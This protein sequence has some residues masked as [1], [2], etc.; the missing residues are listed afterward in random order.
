MHSGAGQKTRE[1]KS[2]PL[3][4]LH[5]CPFLCH[6]LERGR[7]S[8]KIREGSWCAP[9]S[10]AKLLVSEAHALLVIF[11]VSACP[12]SST[13]SPGIMTK[14]RSICLFGSCAVVCLFL[15]SS[16]F[17][18]HKMICLKK[19]SLNIVIPSEES[20]SSLYPRV[21]PH[22]ILW[23]TWVGIRQVGQLEPNVLFGRQA[24][25]EGLVQGTTPHCCRVC[26]GNR[27]GTEWKTL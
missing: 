15:W 16:F 20:K 4:S 2:S 23:A 6:S 22:V 3:S 14:W 8:W 27:G 25:S 18:L 26:P 24:Y 7:S 13:V 5:A 21:L 10:P 11:S 1:V 9:S 12:C 17:L 19:K